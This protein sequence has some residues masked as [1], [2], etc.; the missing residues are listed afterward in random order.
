MRQGVAAA[1]LVLGDAVLRSSLVKCVALAGGWGGMVVH[2]ALPGT[3]TLQPS[4]SS[5]L[6]QSALHPGRPQP[7]S[8]ARRHD[9]LRLPAA[10]CV[11][12]N[13]KED[14]WEGE[15]KDYVLYV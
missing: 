4:A 6:S 11:R 15:V 5:F 14:R 1:Y 3:L 7:P 12:G 2:P 13:C 9:V 10:Q 8:S